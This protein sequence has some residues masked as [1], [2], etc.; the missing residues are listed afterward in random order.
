VGDHLYS[1]DEE[2]LLPATGAKTARQKVQRAFAQQFLCPIE[3]LKAFLN[4]ERPNSEQMEAAARE[5]EVSPLLIRNTLV[6]HG[7]IDRSMLMEF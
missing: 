1:R 5:F 7:L 4:T 2:W 6:N 3:D